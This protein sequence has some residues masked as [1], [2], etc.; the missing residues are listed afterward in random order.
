MAFASSTAVG[1][2]G[3]AWTRAGATVP[4]LDVSDRSVDLVPGAG[5]AEAAG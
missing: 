4:A 1:S 2:S 3:A 5:A